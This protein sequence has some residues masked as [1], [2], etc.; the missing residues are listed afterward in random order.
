MWR[1]TQEAG[2][3]GLEKDVPL[4][5]SL[6]RDELEVQ[7]D[8]IL[9]ELQSARLSGDTSVVTELELYRDDLLIQE[10][11]LNLVEGNAALNWL[12]SLMRKFL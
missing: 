8:G 10:R 2:L 6:S 7:L 4:N 5:V 3:S 1:G 12:R 9:Q 11:A